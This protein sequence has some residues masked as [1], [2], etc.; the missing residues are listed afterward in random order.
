[1][2]SRAADAII[3]TNYGLFGAK[4]IAEIKAHARKTYDEYYRNIREKIP[5]ERRLEYSMG[6]GWEPLCTFLGKDV[7][8]VPFPRLNDSDHRKKSQQDGEMKV[9]LTS[10][11][12]LAWMG[13]GIDAVGT[14]VWH[15]RTY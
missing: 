5:A 12:K 10:V 13:L 8:D 9:F 6:D 11:K 2:H 1:M 7:P 3:K 14:A 15:M 4:N